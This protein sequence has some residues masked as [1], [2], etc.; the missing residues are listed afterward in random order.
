MKTTCQ[1]ALAAASLAALVQL[2]A[3]V[4]ITGHPTN[5]VV[6]LG[7]TVTLEV[8]ATSTAPP[9]TYLWYG[10][11]ALLPDQTNRTLVLNHIQ[12][13]QAGEYYIV[14]NDAD[15]QPVQ[16]NIAT[17]TVDP[18]FKKITEG[19][20]V[21]DA[22]ETETSVWWD[23]DNDGD[24][25][26]T[27]QVGAPHGPGALQSFY[28]N[29]G[30]WV[31]TKITTN[32]IAQSSKRGEGGVA[33]D[34]DNDG[35]LDLFVGSN[36]WQANE[37]RC[38]LF[39]NGG[40]GRFTTVAEGPWRGE[41]LHTFDP[42]FADINGDGLL[43]LFILNYDQ[44]A[45]AYLQTGS[46]SFV[47]VTAAHVG[48]IV[49]NP[50][51]SY[52]AAWVDYDNDGDLDL[53]TENY[54]GLTRLHENNGRGFFTIASS[55]SFPQSPGGQGVWADF[56]NDG[57]LE[58]FVGGDT[59]SGPRPNALYRRDAEGQFQNVASETGVALTMATWGSAVGDF[60]NDGWLDIFALHWYTG[61]A[62]PAKTNV[63]F[64]N[65]GDG[66]FAAIDVG[67]P[68]RDGQDY[69]VTVRW[70][71][72]NHDGFLDLFM[73]CGTADG[74]T[75]YPRVNH[76]YR[77]NGPAIGNTNH[78]LKVKLNGQASNR[79]GIGA[80]IRVKATISG[81]EVWQVRELTGNGMSETCP[82]LIAHFGLGNATQAD[83]VRV[84][85]PSGNVQELTGVAPDQSLT[86][87]EQVMITPVRPSS[88]LGGSVTLTSQLNGTWQWYHDSVA[89]EGQTAKTLTLSNIQAADAGR[90]SVVV[91]AASG[92]F[93]NYVYLLV[94]T[95][96]ERIEMGDTTASW[97]CAWGDY[98]ND[99][100][101][102]LFV[103]VG[104]GGSHKAP[105]LYRN[106]RDG[107]LIRVTLRRGR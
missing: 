59:E 88:S 76:L 2:D 47:K 70:V 30:S 36:A 8:N 65:R 48:S 89:L 87:T 5:Q 19:P 61:A 44:P 93:T 64:H 92:L 32:A 46:G 12:L 85:W 82:G 101:P 16:S 79:S 50:G 96:F 105:D 73:A 11:G 100:Y 34:V 40:N 41:V 69:R 10:K 14:V 104:A 90:Y 35:D 17:V 77:N 28:R 99:D 58:L 63:L 52:N 42:S 60:D 26:L 20:V 56:D 39:R 27:V 102:D 91:T 72:A 71:D 80:K 3:E 45:C 84:E 97:G 29:E 18:T 53:W 75:R 51:K 57:E 21:E 33:G 95:Q 106:N 55:V 78:W 54:Q 13:D 81:Q 49:G 74:S 67:S 15:N 1:L 43:D 24:L 6:S 83:I 9:L 62:S 68:N 22:E 31:F 4:T 25:D 37:P 86:V 66:T 38:D 7:A 94:D 103:G 23:Y 107:S 98:D